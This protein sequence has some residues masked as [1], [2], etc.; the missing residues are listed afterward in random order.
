MKRSAPDFEAPR[1]DS[2]LSRITLW[3]AS[4]QQIAAL[5]LGCDGLPEI[6]QVYEEPLGT[7][8]SDMEP[9]PVI[10]VPVMQHGRQAL[11]DISQVCDESP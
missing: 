11:E 10:T 5:D 9:G 4:S 2:Y 3:K 8:A 6:M 7:F 1:I